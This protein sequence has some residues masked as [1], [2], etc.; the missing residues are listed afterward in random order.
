MIDRK[1][2]L[3]SIA[4]VKGGDRKGHCEKPLSLAMAKENHPWEKRA[5]GTGES[6]RNWP[7]TISLKPT[8]GILA[9]QENV[10]SL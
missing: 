6:K 7:P 2:A 9:K 8:L 5:N 3:K 4:L 1:L 10:L